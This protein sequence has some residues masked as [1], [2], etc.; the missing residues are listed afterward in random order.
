MAMAELIATWSKDPSTKVG[1]VI[2]D[3]KLLVQGMGY[4]GFARGVQD[5]EAR[6]ADRE[7]KY[8]MIVH[9]E[10]NAIMNAM[11]GGRAVQDCTLYTTKP[12]CSTCAKLIVQAG[13]T[14]V[15]QPTL[16]PEDPAAKR[17]ESD[18]KISRTMFDEAGV[19]VFDL[20]L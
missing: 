4:N 13:I 18:H 12:P 5:T 11:I 10:T 1:A 2:V 3:R 19:T 7:L 15:V 20:Q 9:S 6:Y 8:A 16:D 14:C 17:W